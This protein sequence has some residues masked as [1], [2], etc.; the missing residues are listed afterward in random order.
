[1]DGRHVAPGIWPHSSAVFG[2][3]ACV[4]AQAVDQPRA[5]ASRSSRRSYGSRAAGGCA[6]RCWMQTW[7]APASQWAWMGADR[8]F[9]SQ[10]TKASTTRSEPPSAKS[11]SE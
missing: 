4:G 8:P 7:A 11:D 2:L 10:A 3:F 9:M 6:G 5:G 1:M